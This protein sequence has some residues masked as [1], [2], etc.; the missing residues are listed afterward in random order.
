MKIW[1]I[2]AVLILSLVLVG[3]MACNP[4][5]NGSQEETSLQLVEVVQGNLTISISGSGNMQVANEA[6]LTFGIGGMVDKISV[7]EGDEVTKGEVLA[8]LE[9]APLE[10]ALTQAQ[11]AQNQVQITLTQ[12]QIAQTELQ[13][14]LAR[15]Q[16]ALAQAQAAQIQ[17]QIALDAAEDNRDDAE[18]YLDFLKKWLD[19]SSEKVKTAESQVELAESHLEVANLQLEAANLQFEAANLQFEAVNWQLILAES[20]LELAESQLE[21]AGQ[22][23][24]EAQRQLDKVTIT[25]PFDGIVVSVDVDEGDTVLAAKPIVHLIDLGSMELKV[26]VDEIDIPSVKL[27]QRVII[28]IDALPDLLL[29]GK[30]NSINPVPLVDAG[31]IIYDVIINFDIPEDSALRVG[32]SATADIV[33]SE[34]INVL[35]VPSRAITQDSQGNPIVKIMV[36]EQ[37]QERPVVTGISD[38][39]ETEIAGGLSEGETVVI[40][41][42]GKTSSSRQGGG[43]FG[44]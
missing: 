4:F 28:S 17:A 41:I 3:S 12:A 32:M 10:L 44:G 6:K 13:A 25:A 8:K 20:Q 22:A 40:E 24:E 16:A 37:I 35:L 31:L 42:R 38:G 33:I 21:A 26:G 1:R 5:G 18:D 34:R 2:I 43:L 7:T 19:K 23:V 39:F 27:N 15:A 9:T 11:V 14:A 36:G 30:V 29:E